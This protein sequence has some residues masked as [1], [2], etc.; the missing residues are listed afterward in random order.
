MDRITGGLVRIMIPPIAVKAAAHVL[1]YRAAAFV[2]DLH[3]WRL[4][5]SAAC[6]S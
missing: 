4:A 5:A 2:T 6:A 3:T 1:S